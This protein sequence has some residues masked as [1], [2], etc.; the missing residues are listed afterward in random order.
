MLAVVEEGAPWSLEL[1]PPVTSVEQLQEFLTEGYDQLFLNGKY[2]EPTQWQEAVQLLLNSELKG[3]QLALPRYLDGVALQQLLTSLFTKD[4]LQ[5]LHFGKTALGD[6]I[7]SFLAMNQRRNTTL[8]ELSI[9]DAK[10]SVQG[11]QLLALFL[12]TNQTLTTLNLD[13]NPLKDLGVALLGAALQQNRSLTK[14]SV[15]H[16]KG[17]GELAVA[18]I[19]AVLPVNKTL[20][21][22]DLWS[23]ASAGAESWGRMAETLGAGCSLRHLR[24]KLQVLEEATALTTALRRGRASL[25]SLDL[26]LLP[27]SGSDRT[28]ALINLA[29]TLEVGKVLKELRLRQCG[30]M[31][32][33]VSRLARSMRYNKSVTKLDLSENNLSSFFAAEFADTLQM[34]STLVALNLS[35]NNIDDEG[36]KALL[37]ALDRNY[38]LL[39]LEFHG[40]RCSAQLQSQIQRT[41]GLNGGPRLIRQLCAKEI[42]EGSTELT[43]VGLGGQEVT[44]VVIVLPS[45]A[46][47]ATL[48]EKL[49][50]AFVNPRGRL[51][52][53]LPGCQRLHLQEDHRA[54]RD[55]LL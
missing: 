42:S 30:L 11:V 20:E 18:M 39:S 52:V 25:T 7:A 22:V 38:F 26:D 24:A 4:S 19:A 41:V 2:F 45:D 47:A 23:E 29:D 21:S 15:A 51:E 50:E 17:A 16:K 32:D 36:A 8:K 49:K 35:S 1:S 43:F 53:V 44:D 34:S 28:A 5:A 46:P 13:G 37:R 40:N 14:L 54:I 12:Q 6:E 10:I 55:L 27:L 33:Q 9:V 48:K 31:D 3:L